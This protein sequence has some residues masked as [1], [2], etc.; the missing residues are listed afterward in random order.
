MKRTAKECTSRFKSSPK[1]QTNSLQ[2]KTLYWSGVRGEERK[3]EG[4]KRG[5]ERKEELPDS[6]CQAQKE[7]Q[8]QKEGMQEARTE[9]AHKEQ[10]I[11][12]VDND[13]LLNCSIT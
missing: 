12:Q 10:T 9:T 11:A 8:S 13:D 6:G 1:R 4:E 2:E 7:S 3:G 5:E